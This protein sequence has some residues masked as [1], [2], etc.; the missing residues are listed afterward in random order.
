MIRKSIISAASL[1]LAVAASYGADREE[2][3]TRV[4]GNTCKNVYA[5]LMGASDVAGI[6][7]DSRFTSGTPFGYRVGVSLGTGRGLLHYGVDKNHFAVGIPLE[8]NAIFGKSASKFEIGIGTSIGVSSHFRY[9]ATVVGPDSYTTGKSVV[10]HFYY[11]MFADI[12][13]RLQRKNGFMFR[14]GVTPTFSFGGSY[15]SLFPGIVPY[16]SVG[17]TL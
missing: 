17:Y 15:L 4:E 2:S 11:R 1:L 10:S 7:F 6:S 5:E 3:A 8:I 16:V 9:S 14:V 12:G 13:Y